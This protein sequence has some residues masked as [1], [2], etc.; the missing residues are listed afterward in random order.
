[1][2]KII[3]SFDPIRRSLTQ[4]ILSSYTREL[5]KMT[6]C[7]WIW[8]PIIGLNEIKKSSFS[9]CLDIVLSLYFLIKI[10]ALAIFVSVSL[11]II[12]S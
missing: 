6:V 12:Y 10:Q 4:S 9:Y 1:M 7:V 8:N 2:K 5:K 11:L 3:S